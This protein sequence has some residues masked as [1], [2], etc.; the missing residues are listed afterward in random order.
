MASRL[1]YFLWG[2][3]PDKTLC[4]LAAAGKLNQPDVLTEQIER[5]LKDGKS[6]EFAERF[7]SQWLGTRELGRDIKPDEKLFPEY[8]D[9]EIQA[10]IRYEPVLFF[11]EILAKNLSLLNL[12]D[13]KFSI[14]TNK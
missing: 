10:A 4:D 3:M 2:I 1:S 9:A 14:L 8:Y 6:R 11:Q 5:M 13:S 12:I 7:V